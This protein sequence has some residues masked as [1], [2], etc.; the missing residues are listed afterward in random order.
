M[1]IFNDILDSGI[2][3]EKTLFLINIVIWVHVVLITVVMGYA[4]RMALQPTET[5]F[6]K[7]VAHMKKKIE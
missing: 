7:E 5:A 6:G 1:R 2:K 4:V 3:D